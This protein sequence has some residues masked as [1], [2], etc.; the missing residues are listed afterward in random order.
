MTTIWTFSQ[1]QSFWPFAVTT[2]WNVCCDNH[3]DL[4]PWQS[5]RPFAVTTI[6]IF[7]G[8]NPQKYYCDNHLAMT[9]TWAFCC[10]SHLPWQPFGPCFM[11]IIW[12]FCHD[13]HLNC[14]LWQPSS[15]F[16]HDIH[17]NCLLWQSSS[18]FYYD[19]HLNHVSWR[20][21]RPVAVTSI[22]AFCY[23]KLG[24]PEGAVLI[25]NLKKCFKMK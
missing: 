16:C 19:N 1:W 13:N 18:P 11:T 2:I 20:S 8:D 14:L 17:L 7:C 25:L 12:V 23:D 22:L 6:W 5:S 21:S 4:L 3:L 15:P 10:H 9:T 24:W